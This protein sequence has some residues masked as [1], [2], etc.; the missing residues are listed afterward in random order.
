MREY[1]AGDVI[2]KQGDDAHELY[3]VQSG[4]VQL[5][6]GARVL[7]TLSNDGIFGEMALIELSFAK[8]NGRS[9]N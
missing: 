8:C 9:H 4:K 3:I 6:Q 2:F 5:F 7:E 1:K